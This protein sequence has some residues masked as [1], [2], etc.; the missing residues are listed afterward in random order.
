MEQRGK[1]RKMGAFLWIRRLR[2]RLSIVLVVAGVALVGTGRANAAQLTV[3]PSGCQYT[4]IAAALA[5]AHDGD[6]IA[7]GPGTYVGNVTIGVSVRLIGAGRNATTI[8][9]DGS[10]G[11]SVVTIHRG[12]SVRISRVTITGG[13]AFHG[14]GVDND[15]TLTLYETRVSGNVTAGPYEGG[16]VFNDGG[17]LTID[18]SDITDN[19]A[20]FGAGIN[21]RG[22]TVAVLNS[23]I[24][25]NVAIALFGGP[26]PTRGGGILNSGTI[27]LVRTTVIGNSSSTSFVAFGGGISN[28]AGAVATLRD[29]WV[30]ENASLSPDVQ[31]FGGG[32]YNQ[33]TIRLI[34]TPVSLNAAS[35]LLGEARG[36]GIANAG[37]LW[38]WK[39]P[40]SGNA[41][42]DFQAFGGGI[43]N[44]GV[45]NV[46]KSPVSCNRATADPIAGT[47]RGGGIAN[48]GSLRLYKSAVTANVAEG[49]DATGGGIFNALAAFLA[50]IDS[51]VSGNTPDD[52]VGC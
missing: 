31:A 27:K 36:G 34:E 40:I 13:L 37:T 32:I 39:S 18:K 42:V 52:C 51:P 41:V 10:V 29:S 49:F 23:L 2:R 7:V 16:G 45:M 25:E 5:A 1:E 38:T 22:G 46:R 12:T 35:G 28:E 19:R 8:S 4:T 21:N 50:R 9:G 33:G 3:C 20:S 47:A 30:K 14:G 17:R 24:S 44:R 11:P 15:G 6:T 43:A 48:A 26:Q